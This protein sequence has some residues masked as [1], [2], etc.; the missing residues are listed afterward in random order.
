MGSPDLT[1]RLRGEVEVTGGACAHTAGR[2]VPGPQHRRHLSAA[3]KAE[4]WAPCLLAQSLSLTKI[5]RSLVLTVRFESTRT[6]KFMC[7]F[8]I[9][10]GRGCWWF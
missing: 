5:T 9:A 4:P 3:T 7:V 1:G 8:L 2:E 6:F 10:V